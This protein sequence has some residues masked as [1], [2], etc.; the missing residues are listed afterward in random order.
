MLQFLNLSVQPAPFRGFTGLR[1]MTSLLKMLL[2]SFRGDVVV[3]VT[4]YLVVT[5]LELNVKCFCK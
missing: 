1:E 3:S 4:K 2:S 5:I